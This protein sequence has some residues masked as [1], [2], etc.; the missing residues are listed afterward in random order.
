MLKNDIYLSATDALVPASGRVQLVQGEAWGRYADLFKACDE[1]YRNDPQRKSFRVEH[2]GLSHRVSVIPAQARQVFCIRKF[3]S[4]VKSI[5]SLRLPEAYVRQT[6]AQK[7]T[8]LVLFSGPTH[9]GKTT[10]CSAWVSERLSQYSG[11]A[12]AVEDPVELPLE[13]PH[14]DGYC[15]QIDAYDLGGYAQAM[16]DIVRMSPNIIF[17]GEIRDEESASEVIRAAINGHTIG[18]TIHADDP[19][20]AVLRLRALAEPFLG[21]KIDHLLAEGLSLVMHQTLT[22]RAGVQLPEVQFLSLYGQEYAGWK[23]LIRT[24]KHHQL[25]SAIS[26]QKT[27]ARMEAIT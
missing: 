26:E 14:G 5:H 4:E 17:I 25:V 12:I 7:L 20:S 15:Y 16:R 8:G 13:G 11:V 19:I 2:A 9:S 22:E 1:H 10:T 3:S 6:L 23:D 27:K 21:E 18:A 24:G